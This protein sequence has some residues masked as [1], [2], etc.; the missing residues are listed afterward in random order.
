VKAEGGRRQAAGEERESG[1]RTAFGLY[2][3]IPFCPQH[4]PYCAFAV[5]TGHRELYDR[6]VEALCAE[7][8]HWHHLASRGPLSTVYLGGGTPSMLAPAQLRRIVDTARTVLGVAADAE[9][10]L[11]ANPSTADS[12]KFAALIPCGFNRLSLGVQS[13]NDAGL[14]ALGRRHA[15]AEAE[16]AFIAA[17]RAGFTNVNIDLIFSIPGMPRSHWRHSVHK[18]L[19]LQ[20]EHIS[21]YSL[22]IEEG[23]RF[24]QRYHQG[25][26]RPV[27][28]AE[29]AWA[30]AWVMDTLE[31][32]GYEH[33]EVSN[34]AQPGYRSRHNWG[35]W[36]G[37]TYVGVGLGAHSFVDGQRRWNTRDMRAYLAAIAAGDSPCTGQETI[38]AATARQEQILLQLRTRAGVCLD[39]EEL[40][41]LQCAPKYLEMLRTGLVACETQ[42]L[43]LTRQGFLLADSIALEIVTMLEHA[44][45]SRDLA[46]AGLSKTA[47]K[48]V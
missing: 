11:E 22:T 5:L 42:Q 45:V 36:S 28:E 2:V 32:A 8:R 43:R 44:L 4:C 25:R 35:Y 17:R 16:T 3:H 34:F 31:A 38:A 21:T 39:T 6:Y 19:A 15:A 1:Q 26:L 9:I 48:D 10:T 47:H 14:K 20:P 46:A 12:N 37:A 29:D 24:A 41:L 13:F 33:Y 30:Y 23:T 7:L 40:S 18:T 27:T